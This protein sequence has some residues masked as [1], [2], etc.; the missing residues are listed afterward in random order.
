MNSDIF[1]LT[2]LAATMCAGVATAQDKIKGA[3]KE[4]LT[5]EDSTRTKVWWFHGETAT[6]HEG[7]TA[8][9]QAYKDAG[10]G[11]VVYYDQVHGSAEGAAKVFST[12]W[13]EAIKFAASEAKRIGLSFEI[14]LSNGYV[15]GGPWISK[16]LS[17]KRLTSSEVTIDGGKRIS[18]MLPAPSSDDWYEDIAILAFPTNPDCCTDIDLA[19]SL[20]YSGKVLT[21]KSVT[22]TAPKLRKSRNG[23]M[24][25]PNGPA[26]SFYGMGYYDPGPAGWLEFSA[27]GA[28]W[29]QICELP[30]PGGA[31]GSAQR[32]IAFEPVTAGHFRIRSNGAKFS[33]AILSSKAKTD[34]WEEKAAY[35]SEF[36]DSGST[37]HYD[38]GIIDPQLI[39]DLTSKLGKD[40]NLEWDAPAGKWTIMRIACESTRGATKHGRPDAMG[41]ECDK[42]SKEAIELHWNSYA[43]RIIDTLSFYGLKPKGVTMDSHEAGPQN[44]T[45]DFPGIFRRRNGYDITTM[46]PAMRGYIVG[47]VDGTLEFLHQ[48]R[49]TISHAIG[50]NYY[51]HLNS[52]CKA[53]GVEF[54]AQ[55]AGNGL[56][57]VADNIMLKSKPG[58][59]QGEFWARDIHGSYDI[60]D[61]ASTAHVTGRKIASAEAF[62]DAKYS[63]SPATLKMLADFAYASL[64]NEFVVCASAYQP[65]LD[66]V[67]GNVANGRQYCLNRNNTIWPYSKSFWDY[68]ARCAGL[69]R[70]GQPVIDVL[71]Y[72]GND[73][74]VKTLAHLLPLLPEGY[75]FDITTADGLEGARVANGRLILRS[76]M[77]YG[78]LVVQRNAAMTESIKELEKAGLPVAHPQGVFEEVSIPFEPDL[79][80]HSARK[81]DDCVRFGHRKLDDADAYFIYNHSSSE[82]RQTV[83]LRST[84]NKVYALDPLDGSCRKLADNNKF[85]LTLAP[86]QSCFIVATD[87][88]LPVQEYKTY[89]GPAIDLSNDWKVTFN[90]KMGGSGKVQVFKTLKDWT[91][92]N[93]E[94]VQ[95][96]SGTAVYSKDFYLDK[97]PSKNAECLLRFEN[98]NWMAKVT[99]NGHD[100]G[101]VW[102]S[103]WSVNVAPYLKKGQ[104]SI[105]LEVTNSLY[106]RMIGDL[107][108]KED[109][110]FTH[111][112]YPLVDSS[113]PLVPSGISG[114][115]EIR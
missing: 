14:N 64:L 70:K 7:I 110:R 15:A 95:F 93:D 84:Y 1:L 53:A 113:T 87:V 24:N 43:R 82:F 40:G 96:Y 6:T 30:T 48:V 69:L 111:S 49:T 20:E 65:R 91:H 25:Y 31:V 3:Y 2:A 106:N 12:E 79:T 16:A 10:V 41:Y 109:E 18:V 61:C 98:L 73:V 52:L 39:I 88:K 29:K 71:V 19:D 42:M 78:M 35:F 89:N 97:A 107:G 80:F 58:K 56:S 115:L 32:T 33:Q 83:K 81:M 76:G 8:D 112:S 11:G 38:S 21:A 67:P 114:R 23:A 102:C 47:S 62:T 37:P 101:T 34:R 60:I 90:S 86:D 104:N 99:I 5:P 13:W 54:T 28:E 77:N 72:A 59:P 85:E 63:N 46:L 36:H 51:G 9:L 55:A 66:Q 45:G 94:S 108:K 105:I 68:Q 50:D 92:S 44:W 22:Y 26:E 75:N 4:F 100:A 74:P 27:D 17:M 57:L 103:P